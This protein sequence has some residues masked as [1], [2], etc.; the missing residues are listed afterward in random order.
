MLAFA[1][2][3]LGATAGITGYVFVLGSLGAILWPW[4]AGQLFEPTRGAV[5]PWMAFGFVAAS[6]LIFAVFDRATQVFRK[7]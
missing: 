4:F 3:R 2:E 7:R 5:I 6:M 1:G